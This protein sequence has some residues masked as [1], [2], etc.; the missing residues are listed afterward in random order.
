MCPNLEVRRDAAILEIHFNRPQKKN[1]LTS[2]M[3]LA[4]VEALQQAETEPEIRIILLAGTPG[5]FTAGNDL[6]D[7]LNA[8]P[9]EGDS[10]GMQFLRALAQSTRILIAA[11]DGVAIGIGTTMLLHFDLVVAGWESRFQLPF[12][13]LA[14][15]PEA[16]STLLLPRL[17][18]H[19]RAAE[20]LFL[21]DPFD[22]DTARELGLVNRVVDAGQALAAAQDL[23]AR[24]ATK[25]PIALALT[26]KLL[27]D[28]TG[29]VMD[30]I[31]AEGTHFA[32]CLRSEEARAV[33]GKFLSRVK[34]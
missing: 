19:Q 1:A 23:A 30:R 17:V 33:F 2:D 28:T 4:L 26:K 14:L 5:A 12:V 21:G 27:R 34:R 9:W 3:Y 10:A 31:T 25:P 20:L 11:V 32:A 13:D 6:G 16:A 8:A 29:T 18:G 7:F 22:A 15:I 24:L